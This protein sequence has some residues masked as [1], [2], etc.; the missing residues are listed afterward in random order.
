M[1]ILIVLHLKKKNIFTDSLNNAKKTQSLLFYTTNSMLFHKQMYQYCY[2]LFF[3]YII[4][5]LI[6]TYDHVKK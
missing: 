4:I 3:L 6:K 2:H 5:V 1:K